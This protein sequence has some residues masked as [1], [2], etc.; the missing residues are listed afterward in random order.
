MAAKKAVATKNG[1]MAAAQKAH[2]EGSKKR[3]NDVQTIKAMYLKEAANPVLLDILEKAQAFAK[4]HTKIAQ[5][6]VGSRK[7]GEKYENG[8]DVMEIFYLSNDQ[9]AG[10]LDKSAGLFELVDY[11]ERQL[12][13]PEP[14]PKA[15]AE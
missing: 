15:K 13:M 9:R 1:R 8:S 5:D 14:T 7:T 6:G 12:K 10:H 4:Y 11:I 3:A 2:A